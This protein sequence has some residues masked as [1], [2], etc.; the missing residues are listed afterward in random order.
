MNYKEPARLR[1]QL[2][3]MNKKAPFMLIAWSGRGRMPLRKIGNVEYAT[4]W[5]GDIQLPGHIQTI[6]GP[7]TEYASF[8]R[9]AKLTDLVEYIKERVKDA[10]AKKNRKANEN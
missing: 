1:D 5:T 10:A 4:L 2:R 8:I 6:P 3:A 7:E 9:S